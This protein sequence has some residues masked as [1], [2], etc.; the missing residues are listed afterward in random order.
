MGNPLTSIAS[1][2]RRPEPLP[3]VVFSRS[4]AAARKQA[5]AYDDMTAKL[6]HDMEQAGLYVP[7]S[8]RSLRPTSPDG[9]G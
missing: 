2:F 3:H 9:R 7:S 4:K 1:L 8:A 5:K 6:I